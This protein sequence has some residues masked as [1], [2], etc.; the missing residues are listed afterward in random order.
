MDKEISVDVFASLIKHG[1]KL[2]ILDNLVLNVREFMTYHPGGRFVLQK[3][4]GTDIS[5]FFYGGYSLDSE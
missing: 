1:E 2:V 5:K 4:V 3:T